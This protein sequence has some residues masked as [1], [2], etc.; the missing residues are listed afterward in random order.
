MDL[1]QPTAPGIKQVYKL[2]RKGPEALNGQEATAEDPRKA[3]RWNGILKK[4]L[5]LRLLQQY[6]VSEDS[7]VLLRMREVLPSVLPSQDKARGS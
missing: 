4:H 5:S 2:L 6:L 3:S 7:E 1:R